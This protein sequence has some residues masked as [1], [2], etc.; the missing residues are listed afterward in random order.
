MFTNIIIP[1]I[2]QLYKNIYVLT[3]YIALN[4]FLRLY[5][6]TKYLEIIHKNLYNTT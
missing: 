1:K 6:Y 5:Y 3:K 2:T 4:L